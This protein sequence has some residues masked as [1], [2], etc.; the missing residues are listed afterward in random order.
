MAAEG[1]ARRSC[2]A[3]HGQVARLMWLRV[4]ESKSQF[5]IICGV[6]YT[7]LP[8]AT[9]MSLGFGAPMIMRRKEVRLGRLS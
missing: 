9:S 5:D 2:A 1:L 6:P 3:S 8:I 4:K 7:A